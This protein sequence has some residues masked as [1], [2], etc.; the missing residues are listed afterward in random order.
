MAIFESIESNA[1]LQKLSGKRAVLQHRKKLFL[2]C[3]FFIEMT[4][5]F[6]CLHILLQTF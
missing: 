4:A 5:D 1:Y 6:A 3:A 2:A